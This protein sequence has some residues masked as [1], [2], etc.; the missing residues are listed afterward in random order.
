MN[1]LYF[2]IPDEKLN[3]ETENYLKTFKDF[4]IFKSEQETIIIGKNCNK[5]L[6]DQTKL[7][8]TG[9]IHKDGCKLNEVNDT[10]CEDIIN[11]NWPIS[12]QYSGY[13]SGLI[14]HKDNT[15]IFNDPIGSYL[16]YYHIGK[17]G[18]I[19]S[20]AISPFWDLKKFKINKASLVSETFK[21]YSQ[22]GTSTVLKEVKRLLPGE[23]IVVNNANQTKSYFDFT[24]KQEDKAPDK[25]FTN[26][27]RVLF[28]NE[29]K[30][31]YPNKVSIT[32]S[33][34]IDSRVVL[35]PLINNGNIINAI[36]YG[37]ADLID[38]KIPIKIC[39]DYNIN[40][41]IIDPVPYL[42]PSPTFAEEIISAT[43]SAFV[44]MWHSLLEVNESINEPLLLGDMFDLLR[45]KSMSS[46]K[47]RTYR[48]KHYLKKILFR[49][50]GKYTLITQENTED[51]IL[52]KWMEYERKYISNMKYFNL[53]EDEKR[54][55]L[56]ETK[57]EFMI[58]MNHL[59]NYKYEYLESFEELFGIFTAG[60]LAMGKQL[61]L[62]QLRYKTEIPLANIKIVRFLLNI[63]P[64]FRY[65]D[66]L[67]QKLFCEGN[68]KKLGV[69]PTSQSPFFAYNKPY[70]LMLA[71]WFFRSVTD[72]LFI[73]LNISTKGLFKKTR[74]F[75]EIDHQKSYSY[76]GAY[77]NYK[78]NLVPDDLCDFTEKVKLFKKRM[79]KSEWPVA[80]MHLIPFIQIMYYSRKF[81]D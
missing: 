36:N 29:F 7:I 55:A 48:I 11:L 12:N 15:F 75:K 39:N 72:N 78:L 37:A 47:G 20:D 44:N 69:Y 16:L 8:Y 41:K 18:I 6:S 17:D 22:I 80:S 32:L 34:G 70:Y 45:A 38:S 65:S 31:L 63:S 9:R 1:F 64:E 58:F 60:R 23:L 81:K 59:K 21:P 57:K 10:F 19:V 67:T 53:S 52:E 35:A 43:D 54:E 74:L 61:N 42:I 40:L 68:W 66:E 62:L 73:K 56:S 33:G 49:N 77:E 79:K 26:E 24:I 3:R 5:L 46:R 13:F 71:G 25:N 51:F 30:K 2:N 28:E 4:E 27:L 50:E 14:T 76:P